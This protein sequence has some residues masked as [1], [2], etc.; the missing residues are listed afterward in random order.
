ME[1]IAS[2]FQVYVREGEMNKKL[3]VHSD[4]IAYN[5]IPS[6]LDK[7]YIYTKGEDIDSI[8]RILFSDQSPLIYINESLKARNPIQL[9]FN[10]KFKEK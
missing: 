4:P 5:R 3:L 6:L 7:K 1:S 10:N 8:L 9:I 2:Q